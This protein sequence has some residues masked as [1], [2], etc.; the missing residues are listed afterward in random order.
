MTRNHR[1][2]LQKYGLKE[3]REYLRLLRRLDNEQLALQ[4]IAMSTWEQAQEVVESLIEYMPVGTA[5]TLRNGVQGYFLGDLYWKASAEKDTTTASSTSS[6]D[7]VKGRF[8]INTG[9]GFASDKNS[10]NHAYYGIVT[11]YACYSI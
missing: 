1:L 11:R 5:L 9:R 4:S 10:G 2:I 7:S 3:S 8:Y 6:R